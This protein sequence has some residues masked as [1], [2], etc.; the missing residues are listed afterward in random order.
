MKRTIKSM[1][2]VTVA[3]AIS[4]VSFKTVAAGEQLGATDFEDG[5]ALPWH[6]AVSGTGS[7]D[8]EVS[9]G[10]FVVTINNPGGRSNGGTDR[11]DCQVRHRDLTI[12]EGHQYHVHYEMTSSSDGLY[13]TKIGNYDGN[14]EVWHNNSDGTDLDATW[15]RLPITANE[16]KVVDL[17]FTAG[18][19]VQTAEWAFH[20]GG[21]GQYTDSVCFPSGTV[22]AFDNIITYETADGVYFDTSRF[23]G[24][25][26]FAKLF[27]KGYFQI[28]AFIY[29]K[30]VAMP[31]GGLTP[32]SIEVIPAIIRQY[33]RIPDYDIF[34]V[35]FSVLF[36]LY[37][38]SFAACLL[39]AGKRISARTAMR[40]MTV[41]TPNLTRVIPVTVAC[42]SCPTAFAM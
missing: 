25:A 33:K 5:I 30:S 23:P 24:Y 41:G 28:S 14:I 8:F 22:I 19:T 4:L 9:N 17:V 15:D 12:V 16:T 27:D 38:F 34:C 36:Y 31:P 2:A 13:Y 37:L 21:D 35:H 10:Q 20:L 18:Q 7:M 39:G 3:V 40:A 1:L 26:D 11:W 32:C 6:T 42:G 29:V